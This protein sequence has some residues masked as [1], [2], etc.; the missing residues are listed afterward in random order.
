MGLPL[1]IGSATFYLSQS[2]AA[3]VAAESARVGRRRGR[4]WQIVTGGLAMAFLALICITVVTIGGAGRTGC[5][6]LDVPCAIA[7]LNDSTP[8]PTA[9]PTPGGV[10][11]PTR[12]AQSTPLPTPTRSTVIELATD[13]PSPTPVVNCQVINDAIAGAGWLDIPFPYDGTQ[14]QFRRI[15]QRSRAGGRINSFFDHEYPLYPPTWSIGL[16]TYDLAQT[17]VIF[18]G[19]RSTDAAQDRSSGDYYSGHSGIDYSP[20]YGQRENTPVFAA[21]EG[22]LFSA[23]ID[24]DGNHMVQ[25]E[26]D[27]DGDGNYDY[28][29]QYFHLKEDEFFAAML[30]KE[31][32]R[33]AGEVVPVAAGE[34]IGTMGTTG[35]S[36]GIHLHFEVRYDADNNGRYLSFER[37]DP[38]GFFPSEEVPEDPWSLSATWVDAHGQSQTHNGVPSQYLWK[39]GLVNVETENNENVC[40]AEVS[41]QV[42][43]YPV[44][45]WSVV[46]PGFTHIIRNEQDQV[47]DVGPPEFRQLT[48]LPEDLVDV[49]FSTLSLEFLP[50]GGDPERDWE[51]VPAS[52]TEIDGRPGGGYY[53]TA[54]IE[55]TGRYVLV[56][57]QSRDVVPPFTEI[58]LDGERGELPN[59]FIDS[60]QV[61]LNATDLG[62]PNESGIALIEYS[63][64]C[65]RTFQPYTVPF[66]VTLQTP[67]SCGQA[68][69]EL[70]VLA[71][72]N[73]FMLL[74]IATDSNNNIQ[75]PAS[76]VIFTIQ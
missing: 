38:Y 10:P 25:I 41:I 51:T 76:Q 28:V 34:R 36:T 32:L 49:R 20:D 54:Q 60:V 44:L 50:P 21:A 53:F 47:V 43:I 56:A 73:D 45:N 64:D 5:P 40:V 58:D 48:I 14:E 61:T 17:L 11:T 69:S 67:H 29:T 9:A 59:T 33:Q 66:T 16:E 30:A 75:E 68:T 55:R 13:A 23:L 6:I 70:G 65:G 19:S 3:V 46:D 4:S 1:Q 39:H 71:G 18:D 7:A 22:R 2:T 31:Q 52:R 74:A 42:D 26:H 27:P 62:W 72:P 57:E 15:S 35:Q 37:V 63:L 8:A 12:A 24:R